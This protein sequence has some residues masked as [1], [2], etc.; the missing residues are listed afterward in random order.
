MKMGSDESHFNLASEERRE[1]KQIRTNTTT[2]TTTTTRSFRLSCCVTPYRQ[3]KPS[4]AFYKYIITTGYLQNKYSITTGYL[5]IYHH[6][7]LFYKY[8]ITNGYLQIYCHYWLF[9]NILSLLVIYTYIIT[10][11]YNYYQSAPRIHH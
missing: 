1:P 11:G 10:T 7:W 5:Q 9:T 3:A 4:N 8:I 2:T 6:Y